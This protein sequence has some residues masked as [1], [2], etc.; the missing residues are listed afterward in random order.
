M[1]SAVQVQVTHDEL[2][3][4][5][6]SYDNIVDEYDSLQKQYQSYL[7]EI[8]K[9]NG[10]IRIDNDQVYRKLQRERKM[11]HGKWQKMTDIEKSAHLLET[12]RLYQSQKQ[13][14]EEIKYSNFEK[15]ASE[16]QHVRNEIFRNWTHQAWCEFLDERVRLRWYMKF[17]EM[18][19]QDDNSCEYELSD[20]EMTQ[21]KIIEKALNLFKDF[22]Y[23]A[24]IEYTSHE[25]MVH[26]EYEGSFCYC[27]CYRENECDLN[28]DGHTDDCYAKDTDEIETCWHAT[29]KIDKI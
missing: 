27:V 1:A 26:H 16:N 22:G 9:K 11:Q 4:L 2:V 3:A 28:E 14:K 6:A 13:L 23:D 15:F 19:Q 20:L 21:T 17:Y 18:L 25:K 10:Q 29:V 5:L 8:N 7:I 12:Q 24:K